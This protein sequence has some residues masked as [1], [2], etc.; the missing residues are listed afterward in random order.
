MSPKIVAYYRV[1][2]EK[3]GKSG[4]GIEAQKAAVARHVAQIGGT[5][6]KAYTEVETGKKHSLDNR[7]EL[8]KAVAHAKRSN[9]QL[10]V[11]KLDRLLRSTVV[12]SLLKVSGVS[13]LA[14]DNPHATPLTLD[15]LAAVNEEEVRRISERTKAALAAY[16][17]RGGK[18]GAALSQCNKLTHQ[19]RKK[20]A[21]RAGI[22]AK[23][24]ADAAYEDIVDEVISMRN[25][26]LSLR[27]IAEDLNVQGHTTRRGR[28][29][30]PVQVSRLLARA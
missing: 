3:Q 18:L 22:V 17:S 27:A 11:A 29:W 9:A 21:R 12:H 15:I 25:R 28:R 26:G 14:C 6:V 2:T 8:R 7:P 1:S 4:L 30:N 13:F 19:D 5:L 23:N 20:G 24:L 10:V 16:K